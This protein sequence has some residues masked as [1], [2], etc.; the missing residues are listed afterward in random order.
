[1]T[2]ADATAP[3]AAASRSSWFGTVSLVM[4]LLSWPPF[5][6]GLYAW[7]DCYM[8]LSFRLENSPWLYGSSRVWDRLIELANLL[9]GNGYSSSE[10]R[11]GTAGMTIGLGFATLALALAG[12]SRYFFPRRRQGHAIL[13]SLLGI[14]V[15][16]MWLVGFF[17]HFGMFE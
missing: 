16:L 3:D 2:T 10:S 4:G 7:L 13:G 1:M 17:L 6:M 11:P 12:A 14:I 15:W 9:F 8:P 5:W